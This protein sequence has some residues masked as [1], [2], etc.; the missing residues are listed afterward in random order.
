MEF[1][2][3]NNIKRRLCFG[4]LFIVVGPLTSYMDP[5]V[6]RTSDAPLSP[7]IRKLR[8]EIS[9]FGLK[10]VDQFWQEVQT[11][12]VESLPD[13]DK[14]LV[15]FL[16]PG[17]EETHNVVVFLQTGGPYPRDNQMSK[18]EGTAQRYLPLKNRSPAK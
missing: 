9:R 7:R 4:F 1:S 14:A 5:E 8:D 17:N 13:N 18:L 15:T 10:A 11:P 3:Q 12:L 6:V 2:R 16:W